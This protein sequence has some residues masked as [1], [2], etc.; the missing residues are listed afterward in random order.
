MAG[1]KRASMR[2]GPLAALF[3]KTTEDAPGAKKP[4]EEPPAPERKKRTQPAASAPAPPAAEPPGPPARAT[5]RPRDEPVV[6]RHVPSPQER[7]RQAF[8]S[9]IPES[10]MER[11][12]PAPPRAPEPDP[13]ARPDRVAESFMPQEGGR[14]TP[15]IRVV[16][17]G[18]AGVNAVNR[19][20]EAEIAGV[21]VPVAASLLRIARALL[22]DDLAADGRT[23]ERMGIAGL[24]RIGLLKLVGGKC[25]VA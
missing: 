24:N 15:V 17:V 10:L 8:A 4:E 16:G 6:E 20:V 22:G 5:E 1:G 25:G 12:K 13:Y 11:P 2:E 3:R 21:E 19:M 18:G 9:D 23:A 14:V 7:L